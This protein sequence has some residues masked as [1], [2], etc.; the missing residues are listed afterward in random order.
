MNGMA[1]ASASSRR[2]AVVSGLKSAGKTPRDCRYGTWLE[3]SEINSPMPSWKPGA[4]PV[5]RSGGTSG[6]V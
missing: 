1:R 6:R 5:R 3:A 4:A 2:K